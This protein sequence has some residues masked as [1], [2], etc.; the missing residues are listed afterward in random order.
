MLGTAFSHLLTTGADLPSTSLLWAS[1]VSGLLA[2]KI[3]ELSSRSGAEENFNVVPVRVWKLLLRG[4]EIFVSVFA[5]PGAGKSHG[6]L[7]GGGD[8]TAPH[9]ETGRLGEDLRIYLV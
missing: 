7:C 3:P 5:G 1:H 6:H 2:A 9:T 4:S 8:S